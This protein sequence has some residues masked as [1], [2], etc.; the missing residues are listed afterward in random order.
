[1]SSGEWMPGATT[2]IP[3]R[4]WKCFS[5]TLIRLT[6]LGH[7]FAVRHAHLVRQRCVGGAASLVVSWNIMTAKSVWDRNCLQLTSNTA[8]VFSICEPVAH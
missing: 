8:K 3:F 1:M 6:E 7:G 5:L 4:P 2:F